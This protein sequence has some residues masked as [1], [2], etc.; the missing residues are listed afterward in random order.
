MNYLAIDVD[1]RG[2]T[3]YI[4][5]VMF[6][7]DE[8]ITRSYKSTMENVQ[9]YVSGEFYKRELPCIIKL[10]DDHKLRPDCI[11]IDGFVYLENGKPGLGKYLY[12][13]LKN[14]VDVIGV[15]KNPR[16]HTAERYKVLRGK[17]AN[18]LY[19]T[20]AGIELEPAKNLIKNMGGRYRIPAILKMTDTLSREN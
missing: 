4:A 16:K 6:S 18:P 14:E 11:I 10:L 3:A 5:G 8:N 19:V 17:S 20:S 9:E 1:Y 7:D 2:S 15:A 13:A 12:D